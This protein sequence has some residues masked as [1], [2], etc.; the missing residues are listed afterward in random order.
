MSTDLVTCSV[1][2]HVAVVTLNDPPM[3]VTTLELTRQ[4]NAVL[5]RLADDPGTRV[6]VLTGAGDRAFCAGSDI[7]EFPSLIAEGDV[8]DRKL[9]FENETFGLVDEFPKPTIA[10][11]NGLAYGGGLELAVCCDLIIAEAGTDVALPEIKLGVI[12]ASGGPVRVTRRLGEARA[13][14]MMFFGDPLPVE[15]ALS[16]GL[17]NRVVPRGEALTTARELASRLTELPATALALV[18]QAVHN[19]RDGDREAI[20]STLPLSE[21]AFA[22]PDAAEGVRAFLGKEAP[23]FNSAP[24]R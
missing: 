24:E 22:S 19:G 11:L 16:W 1:E 7:K 14:E 15:T 8:V 17:V 12:P 9:S 10:A 6:L 2:D 18:K 21:Q 5:R 20:R 13:V 23:R 3:N 4:L